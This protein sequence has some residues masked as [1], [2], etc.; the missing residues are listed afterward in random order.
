MTSA[1]LTRWC[2]RKWSHENSAVLENR[3]WASDGLRRG[4]SHGQFGNPSFGEAGNRTC[5]EFRPMEGG[6]DARTAKQA[7]LE[8]RAACKNRGAGRR[9]WARDA[10][11]I[12]DNV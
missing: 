1:R 4:R 12:L 3:A 5:V 6:G 11:S 7:R 8:R 2:P 10:R 9:A